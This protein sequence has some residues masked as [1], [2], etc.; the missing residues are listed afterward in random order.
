MKNSNINVESLL[1][2]AD[3]EFNLGNPKKSKELFK[4]ALTIEPH[5]TH[6][7]LRLGHILGK[8]GSYQEAIKKYNIVLENEPTNSIALINKGLAL[9]FL[10]NFSEAIGCYDTILKEKPNNT[11]T[12]YFKASS[13]VRKGELK[14]GLEILREVVKIDPSMKIKA[15]RDIDFQNIKTNNEFKKITA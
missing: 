7:L 13:L 11:T 1:Q 5:N 10:E 9:H 12:L 2:Q 4:Q 14:N 8:I 6:A 15:K 3:R